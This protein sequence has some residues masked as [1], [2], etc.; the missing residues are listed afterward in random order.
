MKKEV[1]VLGG[2]PLLVHS[3]T[4]LLR[5]TLGRIGLGIVLG[6]AL[7]F[8]LLQLNIVQTNFFAG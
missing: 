4:M 3:H 8:V 5:R 6:Y 7:V 2:I 1:A